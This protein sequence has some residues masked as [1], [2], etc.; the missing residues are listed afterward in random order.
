MNKYN[1]LLYNSFIFAIGNFGSKLLVFLLIPVYTFSLSTEQ[2]GTVDLITSTASLLLPAVTFS[3]FEAVLRFVMDKRIPGHE[4]LLN[5]LFVVFIGMVITIVISPLLVKILP[6]SEFLY[7]ILLLLFTQSIYTI[8][9]QYVRAQGMVRLYA[10]CGMINALV[11]VLFSSIFLLVMRKGVEGYLLSFIFANIAG[12]VVAL[13]A[14]KVKL[15]FHIRFIKAKLIREMLKYSIPLVP[16]AL[17]WWIIGFSDRYVINYF[18]GL[19]ANGLYSVASKIPGIMNVVNSFFFQAWQMS[20]IEEADSKE[21]SNFYSNIFHI[22]A[23]FMLIFASFLIANL[24]LV[25]SILVAP[26]YYEAWKYIPYLLLGSVFS[27][28]SSFF[29]TNYIV[30]KKTSGVLKTSVIG[31]MANL[32]LNFVFIPIIGIYGAAIGTMI[33]FA[34]MWI[35][36]VLDTKKYANIRIN[37]KISILVFLI[38]LQ[39]VVAYQNIKGEYLIQIGLFLIIILVTNSEIRK[40]ARKVFQIYRP[41]GNH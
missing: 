12:S 22:F 21:K 28:F 38:S 35:L 39:I 19:S 31:A 6:I 14:G 1:K 36:R 41:D 4:I 13:V 9:T 11:L 24:K 10:V 2:L 8:L 16:N 30:A 3:I 40:M 34:I 17:M 32:G 7:Y 25:M 18:L 15:Y 27:S 33:S 26:N 23:I 37:K 29:G 5:A 20:A